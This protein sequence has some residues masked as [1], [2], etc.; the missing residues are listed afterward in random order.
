MADN[1]EVIREQ[2]ETT[3]SQLTE[4]LEALEE[5]VA[6]TVKTTTDTVSQTVEV[7]KETVENVTEAVQETVHSVGEVFD[8]RLQTERHP[9]LVLG[10]SVTVGYL[11]AQLLGPSQ[12]KE[13]SWGEPQNTWSASHASVPNT[14]NGYQAQPGAAASGSGVKSWLGEQVGRFEGLAISSLMGVL[15]DMAAKALP[16]SV[17]ARMAEEID[18][19]TRH[20][21]AE[22]IRG[23]VLPEEK[24]E[25]S[26]AQSCQAS[27]SHYGADPGL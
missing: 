8:L 12:E 27:T 17:S 13:S 20:L 15:R 22:P 19:L 6:D 2:M 5:H 25:D 4:K 21:G 1:P 18:N 16:E 26:P 7:V 14:G 9:W 23:P 3:R 11:A 10:G 24:H